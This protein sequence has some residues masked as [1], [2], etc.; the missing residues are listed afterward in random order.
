MTVLGTAIIVAWIPNLLYPDPPKGN[1][2]GFVS[3][4][5]KKVADTFRYANDL[6]CAV[7]RFICFLGIFFVICWR[8]CFAVESVVGRNKEL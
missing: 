1:I 3:P 7:F 2:D 6:P 5:L 8:C 4:K